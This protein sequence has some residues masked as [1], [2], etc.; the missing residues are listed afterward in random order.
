MG[1][2]RGCA[3]LEEQICRYGSKPGQSGL[4]KSC[5]EENRKLKAMYADLA[6]MHRILK[7][8]IEKSFQRPCR[9]E[10]QLVE[11]LNQNNPSARQSLRMTGTIP[12]PFITKT[13]RT[14]AWQP[15]L[16][17]LAE[18]LLTRF[19]GVLRAYLSEGEWNRKRVKRVCDLLKLNIRRK[20]KRRLPNKEKL[21]L[22][23]PTS[24]NQKWSMDFY[25]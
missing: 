17:S 1:I 7:N 21:P 9:S 2:S 20:H 10:R 16:Q 18:K 13:A 5:W 15:K 24:I 4:K 25:E 6:P 3:Q 8:I 19:W 14:T 11:K 12:S 23:Q 22:E